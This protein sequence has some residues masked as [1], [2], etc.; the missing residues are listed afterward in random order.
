LELK[1]INT[2]QGLKYSGANETLY[3]KI[4]K[5]FR[6][7][8]KDL[9]LETLDASALK[10]ATHTLKGLSASIGATALHEVA[11]ELDATQ[12][13]ALFGALY[14]ELQAVLQE[15]SDSI[16]LIKEE[17]TLPKDKQN[18]FYSWE[19]KRVELFGKLAKAAATNRPKEC[20]LVMQEIEKYELFEVATI[21][22]G[23][24]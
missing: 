20:L 14:R 8:Y 2:Q 12:N 19:E 21:V 16:L 18:T 7:S 13:R 1:T 23:R 17:Q 4:L 5:D 22:K 3:L 6:N 15:L 24:V 10:A 9:R 11:K